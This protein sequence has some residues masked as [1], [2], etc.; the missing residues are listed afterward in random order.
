M[1]YIRQFTSGYRMP[2]FGR[3]FR[4]SSEDETDGSKKPPPV[5]ILVQLEWLIVFA[6]ELAL[7]TDPKY[8]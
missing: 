5:P 3:L 4:G 7:W 8:R 6:Q 1:D 2:D